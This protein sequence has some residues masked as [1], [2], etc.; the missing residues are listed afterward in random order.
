M[1]F[2]FKYLLPVAIS[3]GDASLVNNVKLLKP[4]EREKNKKSMIDI[5]DW[6]KPFK[7]NAGSYA[8]ILAQLFF[9][10]RT[11]FMQLVI[12]LVTY[13]AVSLYG[14]GNAVPLKHTQLL[15]AS[16]N[17]GTQKWKLTGGLAPTIAYLVNSFGLDYATRP[18]EAKDTKYTEL[19]FDAAH[20]Q[21]FSSLV[22]QSL[23]F[24]LLDWLKW[25]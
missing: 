13:Y 20:F 5:F 18:E 25:I 3:V 1:G 9:T 22:V 11:R 10:D 14:F 2:F 12:I 8:T 17:L 15:L 21:E 24:I 23:L 19:I 7:Q 6:Q 4:Y 16:Y